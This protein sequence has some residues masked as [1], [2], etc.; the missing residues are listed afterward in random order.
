LRPLKKEGDGATPLGVWP[1]VQAFYRPD[2]LRRPTTP[3]P[4]QALRPDFGWCDAARDRN[5]NRKVTLPYPASAETLW[6]EDRLYD[7]LAVL[8]Y[9]IAPRVRGRGSA[10]F[11]HAARPGYAPTEGC[12]ALKLEH[13][14]RLLAALKPGAVIAAGRRAAR[15]N[16][17]AAGSNTGRLPASRGRALW[18]RSTRH[19]SAGSHAGAPRR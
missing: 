11:L 2:R 8:D 12:I 17:G 14:L 19:A 16:G 15:V 18:R 6:R 3:L 9:N 13:L 4:I 5:Y 7:L 1:I 10:I